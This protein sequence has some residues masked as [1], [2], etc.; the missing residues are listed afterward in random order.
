MALTGQEL[1]DKLGI[2]AKQ[3]SAWLRKGLPSTGRGKQRRFD[4]LAVRAWLIENKL[5]EEQSVP[6]GAPREQPVATTWAQVAEYFRV[7]ER[8]IA[9]WI[10]QG[11]PGK[12]GR[13]GTREGHFPLHDI[14]DWREGRKPDAVRTGDET[15]TQAQARLAAAKA[16]LAELDL[17]KRHGELVDAQEVNRRWLRFQTE[18]N[19]QLKQLPT[20]VAKQLPEGLD[21]KLRK[22]ARAVVQRLIDQVATTLSLFLA[23]E[24]ETAEA[25]DGNGEPEPAEGDNI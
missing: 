1:C 5:A 14:D 18:A 15:K 11:M 23:E 25:A 8:T 19:A 6:A 7:A 2:E 13:P 12:S 16:A 17:A 9:T 22:K 24:A 4:P 21:R 20:L 3:L 10:K